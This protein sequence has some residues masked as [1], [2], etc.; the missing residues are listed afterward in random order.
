W[1]EQH[2]QKRV[3]T[4]A[5]AIKR[6]ADFLV[7]GRAVTEADDPVSAFLQIAEEIASVIK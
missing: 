3:V 6:G 1:T 4:P 2:D 7:V 5:E